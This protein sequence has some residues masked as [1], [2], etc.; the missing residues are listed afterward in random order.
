M[1]HPFSA[2][3]GYFPN[4]IQTAINLSSNKWDHWDSLTDAE[5]QSFMDNI[6]DENIATAP[7][8]D[9]HEPIAFQQL[10]LARDAA[11]NAKYEADRDRIIAQYS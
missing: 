7:N 10:K 3:D 8:F 4:K 2:Y 1:P 9:A 11:W 6:T 5:R